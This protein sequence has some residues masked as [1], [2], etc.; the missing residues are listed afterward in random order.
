MQSN[1]NSGIHLKR[2]LHSHGHGELSKNVKLGLQAAAALHH[3]PCSHHAAA[4]LHSTFLDGANL[5]L[6]P[7]KPGLFPSPPFQTT[8]MMMMIEEGTF[9]VNACHR[10]ALGRCAA[11]FIQ[12]T[13]TAALHPLR[14]FLVCCN[15]YLFRADFSRDV[16]PCRNICKHQE[17]SVKA[18]CQ[19]NTS[20][21]FYFKGF[22]LSCNMHGNGVY[23]Q[24]PRSYKGCEVEGTAAFYTITNMCISHR[25]SNILRIY[26]V[27]TGSITTHGHNPHLKSP[28]SH[29]WGFFSVAFFSSIP[30]HQKFLR[31]L[32][33]TFQEFLKNQLFLTWWQCDS[34]VKYSQTYKTQK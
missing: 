20:A 14:V 12:W 15:I 21:W 32:S 10:S 28:L 5:G 6:N 33:R 29:F 18:F 9:L 3:I 16:Y 26:N 24:M 19:N 17:I 31:K 30:Q 27:L 11:H 2:A 22:S 8:V 23:L 7:E 4:W 1:N 13:P 25:K 34:K